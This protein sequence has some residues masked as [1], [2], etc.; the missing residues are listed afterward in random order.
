MVARG[1]PG[2]RWGP[3]LVRK[4]SRGAR[5]GEGKEGIGVRAAHGVN[6]ESGDCNVHRDDGELE[7]IMVV[8]SL[9]FREVFSSR[10]NR[11]R[12]RSTGN[13]SPTEGTF[14]EKRR[15]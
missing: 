10:I 2:K 9:S 7:Q 8:V 14:C 4:W 11:A 1:Q 12:A 5:S 3:G 15:L 6:E 13:V